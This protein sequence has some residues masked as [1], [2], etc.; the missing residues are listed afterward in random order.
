[1]LED[2]DRKVKE[3]LAGE[4]GIALV[5]ILRDEKLGEAAWGK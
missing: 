5:K 2:L 3:S 4:W 1:M